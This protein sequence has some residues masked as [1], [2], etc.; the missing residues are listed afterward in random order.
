MKVYFLNPPFMPHFG[1]SARWQDTS[2]SGTLYYPIWLSYA[3][4]LVETEFKTRLVD[5]PAW[6]WNETDVHHDI[7]KHKPDLLVIDSSF[8]SLHNDVKVA[9]AIK[10]NFDINVVLV[11]PPAALLSSSILE[12]DGVDFVARFEYDFTIKELAKTL[13]SNGNLGKV[14]GISYKVNQQVVTT[15][16]RDFTTSKELDEIPFVSKVYKKHLDIRDY[17][18]GSSLY[19][20]VQVFTGRGCTSFC[21]FCSWPQTLMGRKYR[22]RNIGNVLDE[23]EWIQDNLDVNEVFFEDDTFT[24]DK[25]RVKEF[26]REYKRRGLDVTWAC[27]ARV[28]LSYE[29]MKEMKAANCRLIIVGYESG[30][31]EILK[32]I[33]K[34]ISVEQMKPFTANAKKAGLLVHGDFIIG[35]PGE[36]KKTIG[37]TKNLIKELKP[38][39]L[40]VSVATP[41]PGTEFYEWSNKEG[42]LL[43]NKL[44]EYLDSE[45]HQKAIISYPW[46]SA[47]E[48]TRN[49][50]EILKG[51][52]L[53]KSYI[54]LALK[55]IFRKN[56]LKELKRILFSFKAFLKYIIKR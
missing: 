19:P 33:K 15:P 22:V 49:V 56:G 52:Y 29:L 7:R 13:E 14:L 47:E 30:C 8:P 27:N 16:N 9:E 4:A 40:Q 3:T 50:D 34:G 45:G 54:L 55:Q 44:D 5:A 24:L 41:F 31:N 53:S 38:D 43:T 35:L 36:T 51:Y 39:L 6:A 46:L 32:K 17:F 10:Q 25:N 20:E 18:L 23:L 28:G 42:F 26:T 11:G 12:S 48:I 37:I 2:R 21:T 1:R